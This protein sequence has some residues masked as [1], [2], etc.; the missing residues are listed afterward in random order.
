MM[1]GAGIAFVLFL[2]DLVKDWRDFKMPLTANITNELHAIR[3]CFRVVLEDVT[4]FHSNDTIR[5]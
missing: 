2:P 4:A 3:F 5:W 1:R